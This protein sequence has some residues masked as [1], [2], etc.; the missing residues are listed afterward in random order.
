MT[1]KQAIQIIQN[2]Q[3]G[4][5]VKR[6]KFP[7]IWKSLIAKDCWNNGYFSLGMEYG[8]ILGLKEAFQIKVREV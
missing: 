1:R 2:I 6:H 5:G 7:D 8:Y 3:C 4:S